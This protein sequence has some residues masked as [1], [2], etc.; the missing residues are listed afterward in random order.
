VVCRSYRQPRLLLGAQGGRLALMLRWSLTQHM[1]IAICRD[2]IGA[3]FFPGRLLVFL[4]SVS[5][6]P[7]PPP[8][9]ADFGVARCLDHKSRVETATHGTVSHVRSRVHITSYLC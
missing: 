4:I 3:T 7:L 9:A 5:H 1:C 8:A 6:A 2:G